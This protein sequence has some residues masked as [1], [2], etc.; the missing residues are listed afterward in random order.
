MSEI[1]PVT[2]TWR[3]L[4]RVEADWMAIA[5]GITACRSTEALTIPAAGIQWLSRAE[6]S[7]LAA[8]GALS[9]ASVMLLLGA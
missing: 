5:L 2:S 7:V 3:P 8:A 6:G 4:S 9:I 1:Y